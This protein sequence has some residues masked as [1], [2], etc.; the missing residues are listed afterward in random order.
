MSEQ[1]AING[2]RAIWSE[3]WPNWPAPGPK[4][5]ARLDEVVHSG[6]WAVS[7]A[8]TGTRPLEKE[9]AE[10]F[11]EFV[12]AR[13]CVPVDHGSSALIS[14]LTGLG[15]G[16]GDEVIVPGLTWVACASVVARVGATPVLAD[17]DP[18]TLCIDPASVEAAI[19]PATSAILAVHLYSAMADMDALL[20]IGRRHGIPIIEDAAQAYG[21]RWRGVGAGSLGAAGAF[22]AQQG[23]TLTAGE[24]GLFVTSDGALRDRVE[25]LRG[26]GRRY[27]P[28]PH[29]LGRPDL[30]ECAVVQGWNMHPTEFQMAL[31]LD[32]LERLEEQNN[33]RG[34]MARRL[35]ETLS[36]N[37]LLEPV[38]PYP[39]N[40]TRAYYHYVIRMREGAFGGRSVNSVCEALSAELGYWIHAPYRPLDSHPL[41]D[42][43]RLPRAASEKLLVDWDPTRFD[44]SVA[45][46]EAKRTILIHH[47]MLLGSE[48]H[49]TAIVQA[50][51]KVQ[52]L[53]DQLT[54]GD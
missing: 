49:F 2:G 47:S 43:R 50:F 23:K 37:G 14:A 8:W 30:Q 54:D 18:K 48:D 20:N 44:L 39:G 31:L 3:G 26:D 5:A 28:G 16:P 33:W 10:R 11:A 13:W 34:D 42:P 38:F 51:A 25:M 1:L 19:T 7:G 36:A 4:T 6:R 9:L 27:A 52:R 32:G 46:R 15:I 41:Y 17:I 35:D 29:T 12:G 45:H 40:T 21:A 22:S 24:G 53:C